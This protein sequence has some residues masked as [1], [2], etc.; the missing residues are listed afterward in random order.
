MDESSLTCYE[1]EEKCM[2][3]KCCRKVFNDVIY[4]CGNIY[5]WQNISRTN[6]TP[7]T[8]SERCA[9]ALSILYSD[10]IG[11]N[12]RCC[13]CNK[14]SDVDQNNLGAL[15][16]VER[17]YAGRINLENICKISHSSVCNKLQ[18]TFEGNH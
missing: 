3:D 18:D 14:F 9:N 6:T 7:P 12:L 15:K 2:D 8:C 17:C 11:K 4:L 13:K 1:W 5:D 10:H 16:E